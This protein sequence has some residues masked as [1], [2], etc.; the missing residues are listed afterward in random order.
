MKQVASWKKTEREKKKVSTARSKIGRER[1][2]GK[3]KHSKIKR[4]GE[5]ER[6]GER[7]WV[8]YV[9]VTW[10]TSSGSW[11][12]LGSCGTVAQGVVNHFLA[13]WV[14]RF[15]GGVPQSLTR[16]RKLSTFYY[17]YYSGRRWFPVALCLSVGL[18]H[19]KRVRFCFFSVGFKLLKWENWHCEGSYFFFK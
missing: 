14:I 9:I 4:E 12:R 18:S 8:N 3:G 5:R 6:H 19:A 17:S 1:V 15:L 2:E 16:S 7:Y 11:Q 10:I 13:L